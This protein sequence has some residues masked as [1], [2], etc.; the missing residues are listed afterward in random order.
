MYVC[1]EP[2]HGVLIWSGTYMPCISAQ[3]LT[4]VFWF[5]TYMPCI[6]A[7][8]LTMV[9]WSGTYM[10][11]M[12]AQSLTKVFWS[13]TYMPCMSAQSL[14]KVFWSETYMPFISAQSLTMVFWSGTYMPRISAQSLTK[15][16]W[17]EQVHICHVWQDRRSNGSKNQGS[18]S[19]GANKQLIKVSQY[20]DHLHVLGKL[21]KCKHQHLYCSHHTLISL[22]GV[23][24][25]KC[26]DADS[27]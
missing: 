23:L 26:S 2:N 1:T 11:C 15:V 3:S 24:L 7:Q 21:Y 19:T 4:K 13:G 10:P 6:S 9:F 14:N 20:V 12:S 22:K 18:F 8:S 17:S 5:G 25:I 27:D 16:F